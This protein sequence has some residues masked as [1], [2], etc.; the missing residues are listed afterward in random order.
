MLLNFFWVSNAHFSELLSAL[1]CKRITLLLVS[2]H[3]PF[4]L[5]PYL[6][7][8]FGGLLKRLV[9]RLVELREV[10]ACLSLSQEFRLESEPSNIVASF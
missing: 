8:L 4:V 5:R 1:I 7:G 6:L 9:Y 3:D 10:Y 2:S